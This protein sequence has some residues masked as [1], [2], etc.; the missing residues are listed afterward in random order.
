MAITLNQFLIDMQNSFT[1]AKSNG[2]LVGV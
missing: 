1:A 2:W